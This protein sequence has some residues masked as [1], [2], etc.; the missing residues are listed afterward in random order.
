M[1]PPGGGRNDISSRMTRHMNIVTIDEFD[2]ACMTRIFGSICDLHFGKGFESSFVRNG[3]VSEH[4]KV[5]IIT[6]LFHE[7][8]TNLCFFTI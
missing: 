5:G 1:G 2:D 6:I 7:V 4:E 3:K 8:Y